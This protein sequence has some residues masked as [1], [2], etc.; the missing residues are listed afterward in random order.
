M[1]MPDQQPGRRAR[2]AS[3]S[4]FPDLGQSVLTIVGM[5]IVAFRSTPRL[6]LLALAVVPLIYYS[7]T[8]YANRIEPR[9]YAGPRAWRRSNLT[10]VHEA[11]AML[12][13]VLAFG[14]KRHEFHR[15][16]AQGEETVDARVELTVRQTLFRLAVSFIT[17][18]ERPPVLGVGAHQVLN[19][20]LS[21]RRAARRPVLHRRRSTRR[22]RC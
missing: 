5:A 1:M 18:A 11:M 6:P 22:S 12:R 4:P 17:A 3:S 10:I 15:F 20:Q 19:G 7:T 13:V 8:Y 2:A 21:G 16:R 9:L 14:R